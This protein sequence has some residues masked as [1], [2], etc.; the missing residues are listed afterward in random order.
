MVV[1]KLEEININHY[2]SIKAPV[3]LRDFSNF[4][5]LV[6]PN[7]AGKTNVLDAINLFFVKDPEK[8]RFFDK[9]TDISITISNNGKRHTLAFQKGEFSKPGI[10]D[11][12]KFFVR[13]DGKVDYTEVANNLKEFK[14]KHPKE[15]DAFSSTI[16]DYFKEMEISEELFVFNI[17]ADKKKRSPKR[18]GAGF[19]RLF[20][21]LF[22]VFHPRYKIILIDEPEAHLHPSIIRR[23]LYVLEK[24]C[25]EKQ[26]FFTTHHPSFVQA[27]YLPYTWRVA[28]NKDYSTCVHGF[29]KRNIDID[30]F[31]QE[32]NDDNSAMLFADKVLLVEGVSDR[33]FMREMLNKFY[34]K[35]KDIKVVYTSGKG[36]VDIYSILCEI[37]DIPYAIML[38]KDAINSTSLRKVKSFPKINKNMTLQ[39]KLEKL[40][41]KEIFILKRDLEQTYPTRYKSKESKPLAALYVSRKITRKDLGGKN[42]ETIKEIIETI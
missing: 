26:I 42:M 6:G 7:N 21:I 15:Y 8:E 37:F 31:M 9:D 36:S 5:I 2:K 18:I 10:P 27:K 14:E 11:M 25:R 22:Y 29:H 17:Y 1:M 4:Q 34:R 23:F 19:K 38:D 12:G 3:H 24:K 32:I 20:V 35:N 28:R 33:I 39:D 41:E 30:R 40:K 16:E 13:I